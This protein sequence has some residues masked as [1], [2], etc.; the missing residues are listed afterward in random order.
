[1]SS[2]GAGDASQRFDGTLDLR[3]SARSRAAW[4][5]SCPKS[6][7]RSPFIARALLAI[8][9]P[10]AAAPC[11]AGA[12]VTGSLISPVTASGPALAG[13]TSIVTSRSG[14]CAQAALDS[15]PDLHVSAVAGEASEALEAVSD[16]RANVLLLSEGLPG[17]ETVATSQQ[18][19]ATEPDCEIVVLA[20]GS[21]TTNRAI[22]LLRAGA[23][24]YLTKEVALT[25]L[26][27]G[28]RRGVDLFD[29]VAPTRMG[30]NGTAFSSAGRLN[31]K[32]AEYRA[33]GDHWVP[34][35]MKGV[36][37]NAFTAGLAT[38]GTGVGT[39]ATVGAFLMP[40]ILATAMAQQVARFAEHP[41]LRAFATA[42]APATVGLLGVTALSL[43]HDLLGSWHYLVIAGTAL[44]LNALTRIHPLAL[45]AGGALGGWLV[46]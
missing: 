41:L 29:C 18:I 8:S 42:A 5:T 33:D 35:V 22:S 26:I 20:S 27:E 11:A 39:A 28:V 14:C 12:A 30:R 2:C 21:V 46:G 13:T 19:R 37:R 9:R 34:A 38:I 36:A 17:Q 44:V 32:R 16:S 6:R 3:C 4:E 25:D 23:S 45:L 15:E 7:P 24:G 43:S 40:W 10:K 1:M 31:I